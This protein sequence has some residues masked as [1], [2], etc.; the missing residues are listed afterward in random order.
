MILDIAS[1]FYGYNY[2]KSAFFLHHCQRSLLQE[3]EYHS[4]LFC[5]KI[6]ITT[7]SES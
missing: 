5:I 2:W 3:G 7:S 4:E 1:I 6:Y